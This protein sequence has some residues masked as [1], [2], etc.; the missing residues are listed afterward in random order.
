MFK[1]LEKKIFYFKILLL[2]ELSS[3]NNTYKDI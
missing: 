1:T 2:M 3:N